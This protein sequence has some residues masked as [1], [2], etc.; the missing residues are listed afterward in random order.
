[1]VDAVTHSDKNMHPAGLNPIVG[2]VALKAVR[3][4]G[5][6]RRS[7]YL[8]QRDGPPVEGDTDPR[9]KPDMRAIFSP[10]VQKLKRPRRAALLFRDEPGFFRWAEY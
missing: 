3:K 7:L 1:M 4:P 10:H 2:T 5:Y 6:V 8:A 9:N